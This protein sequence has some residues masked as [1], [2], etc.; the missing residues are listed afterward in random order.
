MQ[1]PTD[2][3][4]LPPKF[5]MVRIWKH[6]EIY[7]YFYSEFDV[8][9]FVRN[10]PCEYFK[11]HFEMEEQTF[12]LDGMPRLDLF[13]KTFILDLLKS[14]KYLGGYSGTDIMRLPMVTFYIN[15][16]A[17]DF[18]APTKNPLIKLVNQLALFEDTLQEKIVGYELLPK[19]NG[20]YYGFVSGAPR[21]LRNRAIW[22]RPNTP[23]VRWM[24]K[25]GG[26]KLQAFGLPYLPDA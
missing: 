23:T 6:D 18:H 20:W 24:D 15:L 14:C 4:L 8:L 3:T 11:A 26:R 2:T 21:Y 1:V 25:A 5:V 12:A 22:K 13:E 9:E 19:R 17:D 10:C 16:H 7:A